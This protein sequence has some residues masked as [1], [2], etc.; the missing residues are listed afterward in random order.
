LTAITKASCGLEKR[1]ACEK[2][3]CTWLKIPRHEDCTPFSDTL[4]NGKTT[5]PG[6]VTGIVT[7]WSTARILD[8]AETKRQRQNQNRV[9]KSTKQWLV[10]GDFHIFPQWMM[11]ISHVSRVVTGSRTFKFPINQP[12]STGAELKSF[13]RK[14]LILNPVSCLWLQQLNGLGARLMGHFL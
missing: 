3:S 14:S 11:I 5:I 13:D 12:L 7:N 4:V 9:G 10:H 2:S 8:Q 6:F 1:P